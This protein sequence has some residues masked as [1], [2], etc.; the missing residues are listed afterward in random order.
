MAALLTSVLD[1]TDKVSAYIAQAKEMGLTEE[2][3]Y[4]KVFNET[5]KD[6]LN[7]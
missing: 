3:Y 2:E 7:R 6:H 1:S 5:E 4:N